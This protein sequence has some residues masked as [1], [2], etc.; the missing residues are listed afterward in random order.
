MKKLA[1]NLKINIY[2]PVFSLIIGLILLI[3]SMLTCLDDRSNESM[4]L[5]L[6][7]NVFGLIGIYYL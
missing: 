5:A 1:N 7:S 4:V 6:L 2:I 3:I